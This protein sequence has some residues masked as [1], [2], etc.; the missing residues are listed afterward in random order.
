MRVSATV[1]IP[2]MSRAVRRAGA[3]E[4]ERRANRYGQL[5]VVEVEHVLEARGVNLNR[6]EDRRRGGARIA[7]SWGYR[8]EGEAQSFPIFLT[9]TSSA[10]P[11]VIRYLDEGT[12]PHPIRAKQKRGARGEFG[13]S[14]YLRFPEGG[15]T[16]VSGPPWA[17]VKKV[18]H[19]GSTKAK[20][21]IR[22]AMSNVIGSARARF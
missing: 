14:G 6:P 22:Q 12:Q 2:D 13:K 9:M 11:N 19:P 7:G 5:M 8:V 21:F 15:G 17:Y 4:I 16:I 1:S 3:R 20:G 18:N 10:D